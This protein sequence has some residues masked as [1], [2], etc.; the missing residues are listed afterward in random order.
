MLRTALAVC[1]FAAV[2]AVA[3]DPTAGKWVI[4]SVSRDGKPDDSLK[5]AVRVHDGDKYTVTPAAG[6]TAQP[7]TGTFTADA[8]KT[9]ATIDM[10]PESGRYKGK[11]L[12]GVFKLDGDTLTVAFAEPG[13]P[14]PTGFDGGAGVVVAVHKRVK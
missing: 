9:P 10:K 13:R 6:S 8:G 12:L 2:P 7:V 4:E 1:L 11:T 14:R 3:A 5:G